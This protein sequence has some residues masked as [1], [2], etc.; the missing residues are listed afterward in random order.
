MFNDEELS[1]AIGETIGEVFPD[2]YGMYKEN[3]NTFLNQ[4]GPALLD[5]LLGGKTTLEGLTILNSLT[6]DPR[7]IPCQ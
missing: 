2:I 4:K 5:S 1:Q 6:K 7:T 3:I